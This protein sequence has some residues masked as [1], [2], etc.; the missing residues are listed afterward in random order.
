MNRIKG[1]VYAVKNKYGFIR[2]YPVGKPREDYFFHGSDTEGVEW[3]KL[4]QGDI[5]S[6]I[7]VDCER[8]PQAVQVRLECER[9]L[10]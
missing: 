7:P 3:F 5:V 9:H 2:C 8:G 10:V 6:F 1:I 4:E